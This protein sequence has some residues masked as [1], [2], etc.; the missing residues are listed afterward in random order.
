MIACAKAFLL[1]VC[2]SG[3]V[4]SNADD[5]YVIVRCHDASK[6]DLRGLG[7]LCKKL[8]L[9]EPR[10]L[11]PASQPATTQRKVLTHTLKL[12]RLAFIV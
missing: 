6:F 11:M 1:V 3:L 12:L 8:A 5:S 10:F 2:K 4:E 7:Q 9:S